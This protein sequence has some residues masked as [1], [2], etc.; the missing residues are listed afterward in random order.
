MPVDVQALGIDFASAGTY[1]WLMGERGIGFSTSARI[2]RHR[3]AD[4]EVWATGR[5]RTSTAR[6]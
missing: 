2:C 1:K 5:W 3:A 4:D 6:S